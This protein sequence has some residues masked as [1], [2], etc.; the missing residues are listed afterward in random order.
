MKTSR[1]R[2][3]KPKP[4][5]RRLRKAWDD[6]EEILALSAAGPDTKEGEK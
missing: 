1:K 5:R 6:D 2:V 3:I 4:K